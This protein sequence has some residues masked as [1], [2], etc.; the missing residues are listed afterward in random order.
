MRERFG[1]AVSRGVVEL[2]V[3][4][5]TR[6]PVHNLIHSAVMEVRVC[7]CVRVCMC[8]CVCVCGWVG[9]VA[10]QTRVQL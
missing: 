5:A 9:W 6:S 8:V 7:V 2:G 3:K 1:R 4:R 10:R